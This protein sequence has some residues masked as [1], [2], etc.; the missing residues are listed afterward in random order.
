MKILGISCYYHDA[1]AC[2]IVDDTIVAAAAEERFTRKKHDNNFPKQAILYCLNEGKLAANELDAIVFYEKPIIKFDRV[3]HQ[4]LQHFP[5]SYGVYQNSFG[6][7]LNIKLKI[8]EVL[9]DELNYYGKV[10]YLEH[11]LAHAASAYYLSGFPEATVMTLDGVGEWATTTVGYGKGKKLTIDRE[12][13]FPHSLGLL[14]STMTAYLGFS[15][16]DAEYKVMGLAA[17]GDPEPFKDKLDQ[18]I[19]LHPDG[20]FSLN[21]EYFDFDWSDHMY[22]E[23]LEK[24]LGYPTRKP[25]SPME[26]HY[27]NIAASLQAKLEEIVFHI[28]NAEYKHH[29]TPHLCLAGGVALNSVMNGKLLRSTPYK[30]LFIPPDPGDAGG[31]MGAALYLRFHPEELGLPRLNEKA[32]AQLHKKFSEEFTPFL[33][34][35][36]SWYEIQTALKEA[37]LKYEFVKSKRTLA[38]DIAKMVADQQIIG[39]FQGRMEWGPRALGSR[40]ILASAATVEMRDIINE[41]VKHRE[42]FR[43]FAPV[44]LEKYTS[45]YFKSD[46]QLPKSARYMLMVYPFK[47]KIGERDVPAVVHVDGTGR[48]Q[49]LHRDD[50]PLYYDL[51][52]EYRKKTGVP[53]II[54]TSF[55]IRGEPIV[56]TPRDAINCFLHTDIDVLVLD[57][58]VIRKKRKRVLSKKVKTTR[59]RRKHV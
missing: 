29:R 23:K 19:T 5:K 21:M 47:P 26:R 37:G 13:K 57:Q 16:N 56:C 22:S 49:T 55:N 35:S 3:I 52:D 42:L 9:K 33:G 43:P 10:F 39:W 15:V 20:S 2:L 41:K 36:F 14:Y 50:N 32:S 58:F 27:E 17:Y 48:L 7:W 11:H 45:T 24:L 6:S 54:N 53:V 40:S 38:K 8:S 25:E 59:S 1:A 30:K 31:A 44:I 28:L 18:L 12:I 51:I 4:H 46:R 34:P